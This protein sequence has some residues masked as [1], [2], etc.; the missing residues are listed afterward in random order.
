MI[1]PK[2][3]ATCSE[4]LFIMERYDHSNDPTPVPIYESDVNRF[5][6]DAQFQLESGPHSFDSVVVYMKGKDE[7]L[8]N[9]PGNNIE[10]SGFYIEGSYFYERKYGITLAYDY[11]SSDDNNEFDKKGPTVNLSY[12]PWLNTKIALEYSKFRLADN[13]DEEIT[14]LLVHLYF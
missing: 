14:S 5:G 6:I 4:A 1:L 13:K 11:V 2:K 12:L 9:T 7:D 3:N 10:F 8:E